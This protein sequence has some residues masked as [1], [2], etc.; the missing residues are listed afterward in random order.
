MVEL[1]P[2]CLNLYQFLITLITLVVFIT[3]DC[4]TSDMKKVAS[5]AVEEDIIK[6]FDEY[7]KKHTLKRSQLVENLIADFLKAKKK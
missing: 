7:V 3:Y 2:C 6:E 5:F 1:E 4:L